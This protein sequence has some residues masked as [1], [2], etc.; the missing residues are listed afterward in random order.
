MQD[1]QFGLPGQN[2][3][4]AVA[5]LHIQFAIDGDRRSV[6]GPPFRLDSRDSLLLNKFAVFCIGAKV[7]SLVPVPRVG[8]HEDLCAGKYGAGGS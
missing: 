5:S 4:S 7:Q 1:L 8:S 3:Q 6:D 2:K